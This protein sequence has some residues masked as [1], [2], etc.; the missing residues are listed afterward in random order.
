MFGPIESVIFDFDG[1]LVHTMPSVVRGLKSA[2]ELGLGHE[3]S[4]SELVKTFGA[5]PQDV[6]R[7]WL[8]EEKISQS[9]Q[10][11][12]DF[13][14][15]LTAQDMLP[16]AGVEEMLSQLSAQNLFIGI[17]TGRDRAGTLK[18]ASHHGWQNKYWNEE[19]MLCGDDG[20][21]TKPSGAALLFLL[22]K[23]QL[24]PDR[25][26]MVGDHI[27]DMMAARAAGVKAA[28]ALW[29]LPPGEGTDRSRFKA[30]W[31]KWDEV[32]VD[33]R[34]PEPKALMGWLS[35]SRTAPP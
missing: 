33:L 14:K 17:F 22:E 21:P 8:P 5:A 20:L 3:V 25:C 26:L 10:H 13:E 24:N 4:E 9:Y 29:D 12:L 19:K 23:F 34:L 1:T 32:D 15:S 31:K 35:P 2:V 6:L 18:I 11:W 7:R 27:F 30:A 28:A 16:F